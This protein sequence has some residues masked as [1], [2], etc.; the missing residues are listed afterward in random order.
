M[1]YFIDLFSPETY[2]AFSRS[3]RDISGFRRRHKNIAER[4]KP[5]DVFV[6][7]SPVA[8]SHPLRG[9]ALRPRGKPFVTTL[10]S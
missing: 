8:L 9:V 4:I 7:R 3:A 1:A 2:E 10:R 6:C 5:G